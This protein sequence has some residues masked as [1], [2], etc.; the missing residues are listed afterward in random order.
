ME[1]IS[2]IEIYPIIALLIFF[3]FFTGLIVWVFT[4]KKSVINEISRLPLQNDNENE[5]QTNTNL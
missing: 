5:N 3:L 1:T 4:Y 2:G